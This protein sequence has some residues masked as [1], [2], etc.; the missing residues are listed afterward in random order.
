MRAKEGFM[1]GVFLIAACVSIA[2]VALICLFLLVNSV[3]AIAEIGPLKFLLG[4]QWKPGSDLYGILP[5][6]VGSLYDTAGALILG[7]P[8][9]LLTAIFLARFCP[10]KLYKLL[11]PMVN[12]MAGIPSVVYGFFGM[13]VLSPMVRTVFGGNGLSIL[14]A[15]ILLAIM[16]LPTIIGTAE[17]ALRAVP[18]SYYEG[19]L[20]RGASHERSVFF[21]VFPA[22]K[23]G[24]TAGVVLGIGRAI[25]ETMAGVMVAGNQALMPTSLIKGVLT[26]TANIVMDMGYAT[27]LHRQALFATGL[28]LFVFI[29]II[30][31]LLALLKRRDG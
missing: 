11:K 3:P 6:I 26:L 28:V 24:V 9:A 16:I 18:E 7:V 5:M 4:T 27:G 29:L 2:A 15:S 22:A 1:H 10:P 19:S 21:A 8:L 13:T 23:S 20:A 31:L 25:G 17:S 12:L 30:N 14:T